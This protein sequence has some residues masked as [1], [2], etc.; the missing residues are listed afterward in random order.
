MLLSKRVSKHLP[1]S[2]S[3][4]SSSRFHF[5]IQR[6]S[7]VLSVGLFWCIHTKRETTRKLGRHRKIMT[8]LRSEVLRNKRGVKIFNT[9]DY[10]RFVCD[11]EWTLHELTYVSQTTYRTGICKK[12]GLVISHHITCLLPGFH[13]GTSIWLPIQWPQCES[14][15]TTTGYF[16]Q[17]QQHFN[18][19][20]KDTF[21]E[22]SWQF[23][24][25]FVAKKKM[26][27]FDRMLEK[28]HL[29]LCRLKTL[30]QRIPWDSSSHVCG[31]QNRHF[32]Q[33]IKMFSKP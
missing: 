10:N 26:D 2:S 19:I 31:N 17:I 25:K 3:S 8:L 16:W 30:S 27:I 11:P 18:M 6:S 1:P 4:S 21:K 32:N 12:W 28:M 5:L 33:K 20:P 13:N 7:C 29:C 24:A 22:T 23:P 14:A 9:T 15:F